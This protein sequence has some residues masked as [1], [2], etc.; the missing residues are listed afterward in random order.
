M[1]DGI[2]PFVS[3]MAKV[4]TLKNPPAD[5]RDM[6]F[7]EAMA[8]VRL[9]SSS[10]GT[11]RGRASKDGRKLRAR[12]PLAIRAFTPVFDVLWLAPQDEDHQRRA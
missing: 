7:P 3:F 9:T 6:F 11:R 12:P 10:W 4:G 2:G 8:G 5:W 1:L